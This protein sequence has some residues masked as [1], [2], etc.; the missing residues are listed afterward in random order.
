MAVEVAPDD[1]D[2]HE[3]RAEVYKRRQKS[4]LSLMSKGIYRYASNQSK[5]KLSS[6]K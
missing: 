2:I 6:D 5:N 1:K 3:T 4:E